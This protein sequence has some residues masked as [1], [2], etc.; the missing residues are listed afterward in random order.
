VNPMVPRASAS[1]VQ[2]GPT[3]IGFRTE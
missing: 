3:F 1:G 2:L